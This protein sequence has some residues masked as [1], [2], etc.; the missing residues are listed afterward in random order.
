[1]GPPTGISKQTD[2]GPRK[3][4]GLVDCDG[5]LGR[6]GSALGTSHPPC[7]PLAA[8]GLAIP[9]R[10]AALA[11]KPPGSERVWL[12]RTAIDLVQLMNHAG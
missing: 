6:V 10:D 9:S 4:G 2:S 11:A 8:I 5:N 7:L 3:S 12:A 1:M